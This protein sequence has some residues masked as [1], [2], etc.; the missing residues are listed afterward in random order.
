HLPENINSSTVPP[1]LQKNSSNVKQLTQVYKQIDACVGQLGLKTLADSTRALE[2][3]DPGDS[4]YKKL[5]N[6]LNAINNQRNALAAQMIALLE[7]A[8]FG[9]Q[10]INQQQAQ[11]LITAGNALLNRVNG[12]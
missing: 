8:E 7:A 5:E 11:Q 12:M 1:T 9:G 2:S 4:T 10:P 3:N 6:Q